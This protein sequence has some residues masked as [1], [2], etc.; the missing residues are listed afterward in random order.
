MSTNNQSLIGTISSP[1]QFIGLNTSL[2]NAVLDIDSGK[3]SFTVQNGSNISLYIDRY[4]NVGINT[5]NP[6]T[7]L[8]IASA[9]GACLRLRYGTST[10]AY[11]N[12]F[13][14]NSG[15][16]AINTNSGAITT[17]GSINLS[18]HDGSAIGLKL[19][20]TLVTATAAQLNFN[21]VTA[22]T[23]ANGKS[24]VLSSTGTISGIASLSATSLTG[25]LQTA[26]QPNI[27][28][29]GT[30][31]GATITGTL[32]LLNASL[33]S[34][35]EQVLYLGKSVSTYNAM[36]LSY[37]HNSDSSTSNRLRIGISASGAILNLNAAGNV[38]IGTESPS[39]K[40]DVNGNFNCSSLYVG[41][42]NY[43]LSSISSTANSA[44]NTAVNASN[45]ANTAYNTANAINAYMPDTVGTATAG[46]ILITN[47]SSNAISN[48]YYIGAEWMDLTTP[49][50]YGLRISSITESN[51]NGFAALSCNGGCYFGGASN[52]NS[53]LKIGNTSK[54]TY[55]RNV[56][57]GQ[58]TSPSSGTNGST[59]MTITHNYGSTSY[60][61]FFQVEFPGYG[62]GIVI[63]I[64]TISQNYTTIWPVRSNGTG[65]GAAFTVHWI[66]YGL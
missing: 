43:S 32:N 46:R 60:K 66:L 9:N 40:L 58:V 5:K 17:T 27:T 3:S 10:T 59:T 61:I 15:D 65:W 41:G 55:I 52:F 54:A 8:E 29:V 34:G 23:A 49:A 16:L 51:G 22:G 24:L 53:G 37:Y 13:M 2:T 1:Q 18:G 25:T 35:Y 56:I 6:G 39:Y 21:T 28:S 30:L 62:D 11:S 64:A 26:A 4:S 63:N 42:T 47:A 45:T 48:L 19:G 44:Y 50:G 31:T 20:G 57:M 12:I 7:Q 38:G 33:T 14:T 36:F